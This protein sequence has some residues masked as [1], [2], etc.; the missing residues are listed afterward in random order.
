[1]RPFICFAPALLLSLL[2][3]CND[4]NGSFAKEGSQADESSPDDDEIPD[5]GAPNES[6]AE[7]EGGGG[8]PPQPKDL[9]LPDDFVR[10]TFVPSWRPQVEELEIQNYSHVAW[11]TVTSH[12]DGSLDTSEVDM[13]KLARLK[14]RADEH[15]AKVLITV[16]HGSELR[17]VMPE[18]DLRA[19]FV[20]ELVEFVDENEL[21]G[22]DLD[23]EPFD[24]ANHPNPDDTVGYGKLAS[25]LCPRLQDKG[26][27]CTTDLYSSSFTGH[28]IPDELLEHADFFNIM[29]YDYE[30]S[31]SARSAH[32]AGWKDCLAGLEYWENQRGIPRSK[33]VIGLPAYGR[34]FGNTDGPGQS[35]DGLGSAPEGVWLYSEI[36]AGLEDGSL[37]IHEDEDGA[38]ATSTD[39]DSQETI[40]FASYG[41][42][43]MRSHYAQSAGYLGVMIWEGTMDIHGTQSLGVA[44][45]SP[46]PQ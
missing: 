26:L 45:N 43:E 23:W 22:V 20:D 11:F 37:E 44:L 16:A 36:M 46:A 25:D 34:A 2:A 3:S 17:P 38:Y 39:L 19:R 41:D 21:A 9:A 4:S 32:H 5:S 18:K 27:L 13:D 33:I 1:M 8:A 42:A 15:Q 29:L 40:F 28:M 10:F 6:E 30:G 12:A 7:A 14:E 24:W 31:W 35:F